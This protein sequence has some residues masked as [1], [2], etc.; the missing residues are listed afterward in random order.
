MCD[1]I[2]LSP[3][4]PGM[5]DDYE[6]AWDQFQEF[7]TAMEAAVSD[8]GTKQHLD[9]VCIKIPVFGGTHLERSMDFAL[10]V[11]TD[12]N[13]K[14]YPLYLSLGNFYTPEYMVKGV[15]QSYMNEQRMKDYR[16]IAEAIT[17]YPE[18]ANAIFLP[19]LHVLAYGNERNR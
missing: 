6:D 9:R 7:L 5:V 12:I 17:K 10:M 3:K 1:Q 11:A 19:Q 18:L 4:G 16:E 2:T 15:T 14:E 13:C 8:R